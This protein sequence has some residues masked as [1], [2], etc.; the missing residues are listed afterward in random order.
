MITCGWLNAP[1][2]A[3]TKSLTRV[4]PLDATTP[5]GPCVEICA[6]T[7]TPGRRKSANVV[8]LWSRIFMSIPPRQAYWLAISKE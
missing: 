3:F 6:K 7:P 8:L 5:S 4:V 2:A 1:V